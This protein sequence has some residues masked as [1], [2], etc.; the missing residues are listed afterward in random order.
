[1]PIS[2]F[3]ESNC[4]LGDW[5]HLKRWSIIK[6]HCLPLLLLFLL[7]LS[8]DSSFVCTLSIPPVFQNS[9]FIPIFCKVEILGQ[10]IYL[11]LNWVVYSWSGMWI[12]GMNYYLKIIIHNQVSEIYS[13]DEFLVFSMNFL[14]NFIKSI[15]LLC[16]FYILLRILDTS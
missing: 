2:F 4:W 1:M 16:F 14:F 9:S 10:L 5:I 15:F 11:R 8:S 7:N 13:W 6:T 3:E 12:S